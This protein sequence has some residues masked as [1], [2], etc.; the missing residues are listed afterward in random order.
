MSDG[1][2]ISGIDEAQES[3]EAAKPDNITTRAI[4]ADTE[5]AVFVEF[6]TIS[7]AAQPFIRPAVREVLRNPSRH[8][9]SPDTVDEI[10]G[11]LVEA[12]ADLAKRKAPVDTGRLRDSIQVKEV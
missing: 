6:G 12:I 2:T 7:Q 5:Y 4:V 8:V 3:V 9:N 11:D 1:I 10:I